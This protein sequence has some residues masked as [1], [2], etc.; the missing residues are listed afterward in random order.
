MSAYLLNNGFEDIYQLDGGIH[1]YMEK[2]PGKDFL[3]TLYTFDGRLTMDFGGDREIVGKCYKCS[4]KTERYENCANEICHN[5]M[6][7]CDS[8]LHSHDEEKFYCTPECK[9][10]WEARIESLANSI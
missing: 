4:D 10:K 2:F 9:A 1:T 3:G 5:L 8:C 7:V 6:L